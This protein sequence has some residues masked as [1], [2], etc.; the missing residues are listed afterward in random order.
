MVASYSTICEGNPLCQLLLLLTFSNNTLVLGF[1][2]RLSPAHTGVPDLYVSRCRGPTVL[3]P[4]GV[5]CRVLVPCGHN[6]H[7]DGRERQDVTCGSVR[8]PFNR[9]TD[10][11]NV[12]D[13]RKKLVYRCR[14]AVEVDHGLVVAGPVLPGRDITY[15]VASKGIGK[16]RD[17]TV[18][19]GRVGGR[20]HRRRG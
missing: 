19:I 10:G 7:R 8:Q 16:V 11:P 5:P 17:P 4:G 12:R 1:P 20:A 13:V 18:A 14:C 3:Q 9:R 15:G 2:V 6:V